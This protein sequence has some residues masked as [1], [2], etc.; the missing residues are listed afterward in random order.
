MHLVSQ[1]HTANT[2]EEACDCDAKSLV[3]DSRPGLKYLPTFKYRFSFGSQSDMKKVN[4]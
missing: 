4:I 3:N 2:S 1:R